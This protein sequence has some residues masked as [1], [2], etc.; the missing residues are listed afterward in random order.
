MNVLEKACLEKK[1]NV[2]GA[3]L[4]LLKNSIPTLFVDVTRLEQNSLMQSINVLKI[5]FVSF[6]SDQED[7][8]LKNFQ[9]R[10]LINRK[11]PATCSYIYTAKMLTRRRR[12]VYNFKHCPSL[13]SC[14]MKNNNQHTR[15]NSLFN[16]IKKCLGGGT[17]MNAVP[18]SQPTDRPKVDATNFCCP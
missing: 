8:K 3:K 9:R 4:R 7:L 2:S 16:G 18:T 17:E 14:G 5:F 11:S 13:M 15:Y 1:E 10:F 6:Y 12:D